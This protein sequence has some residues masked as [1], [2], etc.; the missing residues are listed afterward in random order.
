MSEVEFEGVVNKVFRLRV[1]EE[2]KAWIEDL[3]SKIVAN[4]PVERADRNCPTIRDALL[5]FIC[6]TVNR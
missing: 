6:L 3:I 4:S 5:I 1:N 2:V